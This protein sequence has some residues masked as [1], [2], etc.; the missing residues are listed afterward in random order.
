MLQILGYLRRAN[1]VYR[2]TDEDESSMFAGSIKSN[3]TTISD[4]LHVHFLKARNAWF[5]KALDDAKNTE[6]MSCLY[7]LESDITQW[8]FGVFAT[9]KTREH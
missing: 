2:S 7:E 4:G 6:G 5:E 3:N 8:Q 9:A 1:T